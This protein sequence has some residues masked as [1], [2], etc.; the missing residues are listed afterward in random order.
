[1]YKGEEFY[2]QHCTYFSNDSISSSIHVKVPAEVLD[3]TEI[4]DIGDTIEITCSIGY[5]QDN[6]TLEL[7][8][9]CIQLISEAKM[10]RIIL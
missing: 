6:H 10:T 4:L 1:M 2:C 7:E 5:I 9:Q 8:A 3:S